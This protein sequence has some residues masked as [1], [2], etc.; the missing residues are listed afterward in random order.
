MQTNDEGVPKPTVNTAQVPIAVDVELL[1]IYLTSV[2][3]GKSRQDK[4][5]ND[6]N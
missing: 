2:K 4:K 5:S 1:L 3:Q 6:N